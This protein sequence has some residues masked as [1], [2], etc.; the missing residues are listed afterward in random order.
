MDDLDPELHRRVSAEVQRIFPYR[1]E[2][3]PLLTGLSFAYDQDRDQ[4]HST[5]IL[6]RLSLEAPAH[7]LRV[8]AITAKDL[9]IPILTYVFGE[10]QLNGR[11]C[12]VST[13]RMRDGLV[14][15]GGKE[16]YQ[17]RVAKEAIHELG[18]TFK[19]STLQGTRLHHA[20]LPQHP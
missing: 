16:K 18:H 13:C 15:P 6:E 12:I 1:T 7:A 8:L 9:Y 17:G 5:A 20:L 2:I 19:S 3:V 14:Y 11:A 10:A 4:Y